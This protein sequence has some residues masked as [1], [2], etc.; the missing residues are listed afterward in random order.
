[1]DLVADGPWTPD[2]NTSQNGHFVVDPRSGAIYGVFPYFIARYDPNTL[3][4]EILHRV[5]YPHGSRMESD[6]LAIDANGHLWIASVELRRFDP[7]QRTMVR[8]LPR[9]PALVTAVNDVSVTHID[10]TGMVWIGSKGYGIL[11]YDPAMEVF[12]THPDESVYSMKEI[13]G[14]RLIV[15]TRWDFLR[16]FDAGTGGFTLQLKDDD[17]ALRAQFS[18]LVPDTFSP[19]KSGD[20]LFW[21][22]KGGIISFD[23]VTLKVHH[24]PIL[25]STGREL[26]RRK[27]F[28]PLVEDHRGLLW[29][30]ADTALYSFDRETGHFKEFRYPIVPIH[31]PYRFAQSIVVDH[32]G[33]VWVGSTRGLLRLDPTNGDWTV[34]QNDPENTASLSFDLIFCLLNDPESPD[35]YLWIGTNGGGVN[36]FD[37]RNGSCSRYGSKQGLPNEVV[38]GILDDTDGNLWMSTNKGICRLDPRTGGVRNFDAT[39]GLQGDEFNRNA[40]CKLPDGRLCFGGVKGFNIFDPGQVIA[41]PA[42][43]QLCLTDIKL[44]NRSIP[45][46]KEGAPLSAPAFLSTGMTIPYETNM[47]TFEFANMDFADTE[48][49]A[50]R[51]QLIGFDPEPI[52]SGTKNSAIYTNL[53]PGTY[54]FQLS[55]RLRNED[56]SEP[57]PM[58]QLV[59]TPPWYRTRVA[60]VSYVLLAMLTS[61]TYTRLRTRSL[62]RRKKQ[63][64]HTVAVRT[65]EI[66][67]E[68]DRSEELLLNI[69]PEEV[70]EEL[71]ANGEAEAKLIDQVT[72]LFTDFKGFTAMSEQLSPKELVKDLHECF[73]AFD[74]IC[75]K[76]GLEKIKTIGDAYMAAGGLPTPNTTHATDVIAAALEIRDFIAEGKARKVAAGLPYFEIRIGIHTGPVVAG[77]VGVKKFQYDIWGDTVN[78]ASRMESSG[79]VGQV[80]ISEATYAQVKDIAGLSF[81]P[82]GKVQ[83][84]G[85]GE[86]EMYFVERA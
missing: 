50:F 82:R 48:N 21:M 51:Y 13:G 67:E 29:F 14:D 38:Y 7:A 3:L 9:D 85:K 35:R 39:D 41:P 45:F 81:T 57:Q 18:G 23:P 74:N 61:F 2:P 6:Q 56:W 27:G 24:F 37:K 8:V 83:A 4:S 64:E 65:R 49:N 19:L 36:R 26:P 72:V 80:N 43:P 16:V 32:E 22:A 52:T 11:R 60:Y 47:I 62:I 5:P 78:T 34:Y 20:G 1:M 73:S 12:G 28:F 71:K 46:Q 66:A 76:H 75:E 42:P 25:D 30:G 86:M 31:T 44:L 68:R 79:E 54:H 63:L 69:L 53:D 58:F 77:I 10:R 15:Q 40:Y 33:T 84:K 70:A 55:T 17:P 59:I